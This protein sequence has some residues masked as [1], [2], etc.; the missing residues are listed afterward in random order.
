MN[1]KIAKDIFF[2][3]CFTQAIKLAKKGYKY[4]AIEYLHEILGAKRYMLLTGDLSKPN[5]NKISNLVFLIK[6]KYNLY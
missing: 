1:N 3:D 2:K 5:A 4:E 6:S